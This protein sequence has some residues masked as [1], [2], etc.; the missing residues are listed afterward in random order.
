MI[1]MVRVPFDSYDF[2]GHLAAGTLLLGVGTAASGTH[3]LIVGD[4]SLLSQALLLLGAYILGQAVATPAKAVLEDLIIKRILGVPTKNL[5]SEQ[6]PRM[7]G[8]L[9][10]GY[11]K[12]LP[13]GIRT[14][15]RAA[16][17]EHSEE[18]DETLFLKARYSKSVVENDE[19]LRRLQ[20]FLSRYGFA[21][22][23]SFS[24]LLGAIFLFV[25]C[26]IT[27]QCSLVPLAWALL[28]VSLLLF[29]RY[30]KFYRLYAL[31]VLTVWA[32]SRQEIGSRD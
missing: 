10:P 21:R 25:T 2:F 24:G 5:L 22:N 8:L 20:V 4:L 17:G 26:L 19:V 9:F 1:S 3:D 11:Y 12:P 32:S 16:I 30:L 28:T 27:I 13:S 6:R 14:Q 18:D 29:Y 31:E 23:V 7:V 15:V